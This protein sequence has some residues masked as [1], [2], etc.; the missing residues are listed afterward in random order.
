MRIIS[1]TLKGKS[2]NYIK[3]FITRPLKDSV[4]ENIFNILEHSNLIKPKIKNSHILDLYSGVGSFGIECIS[5]G[6][7][8]V[9]FV[10]QNVS[11]INI[12]R[13]N[14]SKLSI[15]NQTNIYNDRI[16]TNLIKRFKEKF[17]IFFLDPPFADT[18]FINILETLKE[19]KI[20]KKNHIII[21][22]RGKKSKEDFRDIFKA[23]TIKQYGKSKIIFGVFI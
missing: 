10:E 19:C 11:S 20:Y 16:N 4:K 18:N 2:I 17:H 15:I 8:K 3:N 22:H 5:R 12:L 9:T 1:G 21:V 7:Q 23:V 6:A 13:E 14:L